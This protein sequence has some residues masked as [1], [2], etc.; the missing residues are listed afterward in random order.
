MI[1]IKLVNKVFLVLFILVIFLN[2]NVLSAEIKEE[3]NSN[4]ISY[5]SK[6][7]KDENVYDNVFFYLYKFPY[8]KVID[9]LLKMK[10]TE[11]DFEY[12]LENEIV[13]FLELNKTCSNINEN[14]FFKN[15]LVD[16]FRFNNEMYGKIKEDNFL[17][18]DNYK[19]VNLNKK[20]LNFLSNIKKTERDFDII[21]FSLLK[22]T[23]NF[24]IQKK[25]IK[26]TKDTENQLIKENIK[27]GCMDSNLIFFVDNVDNVDNDD[28]DDNV[29]NVEDSDKIDINN[30]CFFPKQQYK[31]VE[32]N[33]YNLEI[34]FLKEMKQKIAI[35]DNIKFSKYYF[36]NNSPLIFMKFKVVNLDIQEIKIISN[37]NLRNNS[38]IQ[39]Y[40]TFIDDLYYNDLNDDSKK[41]SFDFNLEDEK[42]K[43]RSNYNN[44]DIDNLYYSVS[45]KELFLPIV[46]DD[47]VEYTESI[48]FKFQFKDFLDNINEIDVVINSK[49]VSKINPIYNFSINNVAIEN[50]EKIIKDSDIKVN[51]KF[52]LLESE[53]IF[54]NDNYTIVD[55]KMMLIIINKRNNVF[56]N[57]DKIYTTSIQKKKLNNKNTIEE[58]NIFDSEI[59]IKLNSICQDY[60]QDQQ[61]EEQDN[62]RKYIDFLIVDN[63]MIDFFKLNENDF[64]DKFIKNFD[65]YYDIFKDLG[66]IYEYGEIYFCNQDQEI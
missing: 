12:N 64:Y 33:K 65:E 52:N 59:S 60:L 8:I 27:I 6:N 30:Q 46:I 55:K 16:D 56:Q 20:Y 14:C 13:Y 18:E 9:E 63:D 61:D 66:Y 40:S 26:I 11:I 42:L 2:L 24:M 37:K 50:D 19:N 22:N 1:K 15:V 51:F 41:I 4:L 44:F 53:N 10:I 48:S 35:E 62:I 32:L 17:N 36:V 39:N 3:D 54:L 28:N 34:P 47:K 7:I 29:D 31:Y 45:R 5:S 58:I 25:I 38:F 43:L 23:Y 49:D 21:N 57:D